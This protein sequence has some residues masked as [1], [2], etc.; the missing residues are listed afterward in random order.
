M[1][2]LPLS[3]DELRS[4]DGAC[5]AISRHGAQLCSWRTPDGRERLYLSPLAQV[6]EGQAIRGGIPVIFPQFAGEGPLPKHGFARLLSWERQASSELSDGRAQARYVLRDNPRTR[7]IWPQRFD[8]T[9]SVCFGARSLS[10]ELIVDNIG[11]QAFTF[12]AA[13]HSYLRVQSLSMVRL[14]GLQHLRYRDAADGL[15]MSQQS[16]PE[17]A[18]VG[19]VDR[20]YLQTPASLLLRDADQTQRLSQEG[21]ADTVVWNPGAQKAA[22]LG[23]LPAGD[24]QQMLCVEAAQ[25]GEPVSL[26]AGARWRASQTLEVLEDG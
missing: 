6:G 15:R 21:F 14:Q 9:L 5:V 19:E 8:L 17:L 16:E 24:W 12:T 10:V 13:L 23:D 4:R 20:L 3:L 11:G 26:A 7:A 22:A 18:I 1:N 25:V 2:P